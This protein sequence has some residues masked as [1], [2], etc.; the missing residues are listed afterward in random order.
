MCSMHA[1]R[2]INN[3]NRH[4][5]LLLEAIDQSA[6]AARG[7]FPGANRAQSVPSDQHAVSLFSWQEMDVSILCRVISMQTNSRYC[8]AK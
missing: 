2:P 7:E 6:S 8:F 3:S 4:P 1:K 5:E